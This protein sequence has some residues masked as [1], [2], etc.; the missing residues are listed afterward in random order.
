MR[1]LVQFSGGKDSQA[2]LIQICKQ[3]G[4]NKVT[5]VFCDT[6]WEHEY[7]YQHIQHVVNQLGCE[8]I[9]LKNKSVDGMIGLC[10]RMKWFPDT[11]HRMCTVFLKIHPMI[12]YILEK[13]EDLVIVQG[14]RAGESEKRAN[15]PCSGNYF[16]EYFDCKSKKKLYK[17]RSVRNWCEHH[18]AYMERPIFDWSAQQVIDYILEN[19]QSPNPL[20]KQGASRVGCYPCIFARKAEL[21]IFAKDNR[22]VQRLI[23]L[24]R[25]VNSLRTDD[26]R[27]SFFPKGKIPSKFCKTYGNG[28]PSIEDI[29]NY[30]IKDD[31]PGLFDELEE[32]TCMS[33]Y[34]GLCE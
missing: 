6:G 19:G 22:Y 27:A 18:H 25:D 3:F 13:D 29:V 2:A 16:A 20:Y 4:A 23:G 8:F 11:Q 34:H 1:V 32:Y 5:A 28:I 14:I 26:S 33:M 9:S 12:D 24:E 31:A 17:K 15:M 30:V 10:K 21:K 7:T